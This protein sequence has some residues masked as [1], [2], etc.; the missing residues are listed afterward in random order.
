MQLLHETPV[1]SRESIRRSLAP[2]TPVGGGS[3]PPELQV[4]FTSELSEQVEQIKISL[5]SLNTEEIS[6]MWTAFQSNYRPTAAYQVSVVLI[7]GRRR[8]KSAL[9]VRARNVYVE[10]FNQ[11]VIEQIKSQATASAPIV[12][13]QMILAGHNLII[14]GQRLRGE[15]TVVSISGIE[16]M[17][18]SANITDTQIIVA[19]PP[20]LRAGVQGVQV[21]HRRLMGTPPMPHRGVESNI[22]AFVLRPAIRNVIVSNVRVSGA[23]LRSADLT[24]TVEPAIGDSQR[25][26]LL[27]NQFLPQTSPP[28]P[29]TGDVAAYSFTIPS[30]VALSPPAAPP[31]ESNTV[32]VPVSGV[33]AGTY[34]IRIQVD[35][36]ESPLGADAGGSY[37]SPTVTIL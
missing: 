25:V 34:L 15:D 7:E 12:A 4:L 11:P 21:S 18:T 2:P 14:V 35:G 6:R 9:P 29:I 19:L 10:P 22:A 32:S 37:N 30:R 3:L 8:A 20:T 13:G 24:V 27:L 31:G 33:R 5:E 1:L 26:V 36:A 23:G 28:Q 17:P 16:V